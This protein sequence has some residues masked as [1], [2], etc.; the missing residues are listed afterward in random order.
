MIR[1][2]I[3]SAVFIFFVRD[4]FRVRPRPAVFGSLD[5]IHDD[6]RDDECRNKARRSYENNAG[7]ALFHG[8]ARLETY[9][10]FLVIQTDRNAVK[11][12]RYGSELFGD[13]VE[14]RFKRLDVF[15]CLFE[16]GVGK[17]VELV[18]DLCVPHGKFGNLFRERQRHFHFGTAAP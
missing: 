13:A 3:L 16:I 15:L 18:V 4:C 5:D 12:F 10:R 2:L 11:R 7:T 1:G 9:R 14:L 17:R 6:T 8:F